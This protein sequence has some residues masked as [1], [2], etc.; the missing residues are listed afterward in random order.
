MGVNKEGHDRELH[1]R[2]CTVEGWTTDLLGRRRKIL[3][4]YHPQDPQGG[5]A[6]LLGLECTGFPEKNGQNG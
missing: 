6:F 3:R 2:S 4:E 5:G 1:L